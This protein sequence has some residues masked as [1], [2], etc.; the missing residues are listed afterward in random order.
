MFRRYRIWGLFA[1]SALLLLLMVPHLLS[2]S[3]PILFLLAGGAAFVV[4]VTRDS[5][6]DHAPDWKGSLTLKCCSIWA[7]GALTL[8]IVLRF[9][10]PD[11]APDPLTTIAIPTGHI[12]IRSLLDVLLIAAIVLIAYRVLNSFRTVGALLA[13]IALGL[14]SLGVQ[15]E[16][17]KGP[18]AIFLADV[19]PGDRAF[20][21]FDLANI[22]WCLGVLPLSMA[23]DRYPL[24]TRQMLKPRLR[25]NRDYLVIAATS[26]SILIIGY[27]VIA[28]S[29]V[30]IDSLPAGWWLR[31]FSASA[32]SVGIPEE[33]LWRVFGGA[34]IVAALH[35]RTEERARE[36]LAIIGTTLVFAGFHSRA[37]LLS[38]LL[39]LLF[40]ACAGILVIRYGL[41]WVAILL[42][43]SLNTLLGGWN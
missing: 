21:L 32:L 36:W 22:V 4:L 28:Y 7:G 18:I 5:V 1:V 6:L 38:E 40:G 41:F 3:V 10:F 31:K 2:M 27:A 20:R 43:A 33:A 23:V 29:N 13:L 37:G 39:A 12:Q 24:L 11:Y 26:A 8:L 42:H 9:S 15:F 30:K 17:V 25:T 34:L 35:G 14:L 16:T 19:D